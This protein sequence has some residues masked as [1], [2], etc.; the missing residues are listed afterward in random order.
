M[1]LW[2]APSCCLTANVRRGEAAQE[3][4]AQNSS[5]RRWAHRLPIA[6][7][8]GLGYER[9]GRVPTNKEHICHVFLTL[10]H[11][12]RSAPCQQSSQETKKKSVISNEGFFFFFWKELRM[13]SIHGLAKINENT[14]VWMNSSG[15]QFCQHSG[16]GH[17][18]GETSSNDVISTS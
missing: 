14:E 9:E 13:R 10:P 11:A 12:C 16:V 18:A 3:G 17:S 7:L 6:E 8:Q 15:F 1:W 4:S 5:N 2:K